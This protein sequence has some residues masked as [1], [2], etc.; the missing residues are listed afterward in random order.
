VKNAAMTLGGELVEVN[1]LTRRQ[2]DRMFE[3]MRSYFDGI[4]Q[5]SFERDLSEKHWVILLNNRQGRRIEG[6]STQCVMKEIVDG[7]PVRALYSGDTII[8]R[9]SWGSHAL[10]ETWI[11]FAFARI[12]EEPSCR[13]FWFLVCKGYRTYRYLTVY[14]RR[15]HPSLRPVPDFEQS[16]LHHLAR[17]RFGE[18]YDP[19]SGVIRCPDD[20]R[21]KPG[22]GDITEREIRNPH[23]AFFCQRNPDWAEGAELACLADLSMDNLRPMARRM[24]ER[25][26]RT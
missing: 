6:F 7:Q 22:V 26:I 19:H 24:L 14:F 25:D 8:D 21:L 15:Y 5:E 3:L 2:K 20:Y 23:I 12:R 17:R 11:R 10:A 4:R 16:V 13:W 9:S 1:G 18:C